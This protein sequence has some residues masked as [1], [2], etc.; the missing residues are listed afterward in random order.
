M[1]DEISQP[2]R[3]GSLGYGTT[4]SRALSFVRRF[5]QKDKAPN[6]RLHHTIQVQMLLSCDFSIKSLP[7]S[8]YASI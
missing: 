4:A 5:Y 2:E 3:K 1:N 6:R 7:G 8:S